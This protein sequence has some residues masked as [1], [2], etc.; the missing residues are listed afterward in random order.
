MRT[1]QIE[2]N[3]DNY[4]AII[5]Q[6]KKAIIEN[7]MG[8]DA[9]DDRIGSNANE[10]NLKSMYSDIDLD[11]N[12][13]IT[14]YQA[15]FEELIWFLTCHLAN[16]HEGDYDPDEFTIEFNK[17]MMVNE[18]DVINDCKNS[19][20][21][22]SDETAL[23][24]HPWVDDVQAELDKLKKQKEEDI[25]LYGDFGRTDPKGPKD[26]EGQGEE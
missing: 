1:L 15:A 23:A 19:I 11:A 21:L 13:M 14:E 18:S 3:S 2:V 24:H 16:I 8:Y 22:I 5:Q 20:G 10:M 26:P 7:C 12:G 17:S 4:K 25:N 9:K 6:F